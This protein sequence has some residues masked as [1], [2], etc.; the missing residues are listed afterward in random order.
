MTVRSRTGPIR[1]WVSVRHCCRV[2]CVVSVFSPDGGFRE[3]LSPSESCSDDF[4][5]EFG[6]KF[7]APCALNGP[8]V[9]ALYSAQRAVGGWSLCYDND[10]CD[11]TCSHSGGHGNN[12]RI[13]ATSVVVIAVCVGVGVVVVVAVG[14]LGFGLQRLRLE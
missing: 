7:E 2:E 10:G 8:C 14:P 12:A 1:P 13:H 6:P 11:S 5:G 9:P 4:S 3:L